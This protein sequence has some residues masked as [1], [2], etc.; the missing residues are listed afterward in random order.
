MHIHYT[1]YFNFL[2]GL[3]RDEGLDM[4][5][6]IGKAHKHEWGMKELIKN[7]LRPTLLFVIVRKVL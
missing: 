2:T 1:L 5:S 3:T 7:F 4:I 6:G